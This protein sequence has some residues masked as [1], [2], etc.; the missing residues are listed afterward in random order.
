MAEKSYEQISADLAESLASI[1][2]LEKKNFELSEANGELT[3]VNKA[4]TTQNRDLQAG[5]GLAGAKSGLPK[6]VLQDIQRRMDHGLSQEHATEAALRQHG[7]NAKLAEKAKLVNAAAAK[8]E[9]DGK[10]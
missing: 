6:E 1:A 10:K 3:A 7:H 8:A 4:L 9:K 5:L 2:S